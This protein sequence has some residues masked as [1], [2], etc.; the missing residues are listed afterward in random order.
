VVRGGSRRAH[1]RLPHLAERVGA[2]GT[3]P[4]ERFSAAAENALM[5]LSE[6]DIDTDA[7]SDGMGNTE[8]TEKQ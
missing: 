3:C 6:P 8:A 7:D 1:G 5:V 2:F 4:P